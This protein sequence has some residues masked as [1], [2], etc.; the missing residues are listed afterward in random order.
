MKVF[1][2]D[3]VHLYKD[4]KGDYYSPSIYDDRFFDRFSDVFQEVYFCAKI[5]YIPN[6]ESTK[7]IKIQ[8]KDIIIVELPWFRG[9][10]GLLLN[11]LKVRSVIRR[12]MKKTDVCIFR[13][14]QV[15]SLIGYM[16]RQKK[17]FI[18]E[19]V[20]DPREYFNG[21]FRFVSLFYLKRMIKNAVGVSYI[22]KNILQ[23]KYPIRGN[24][25]ITESYLTIDID[26]NLLSKPRIYP[27]TIKEFK[28]IH[29]A[30]NIESDSKGHST[31][32]N[33]VNHVIKNGYKVSVRFIG[34]GSFV[35][36]YSE[37]AES[38]NIKDY[39]HFIGRI[40]DKNKIYHE[41]LS[42]DLF[43]F[44]T[45]H[46]GLG[47]VNLEAQVCGLPCLASPV[48]GVV[49]LYDMKYLINPYD[50]Q[51]YGNKIIELINNPKELDR[52][53]LENIENVKQYLKSKNYSKR[54]DFYIK[55]KSIVEFP[56]T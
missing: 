27:D 32:I 38:L 40:H 49:E 37:M 42:A 43:I 7:F 51:S 50:Y 31:V 48:G 18:I 52:M 13:S 24:N 11:Y 17:P 30:N 54:H 55:F 41:L 36:Y 46:E 29:I 21:I 25:K 12:F 8:R 1:V 33:A 35:K 9:L 14:V 19:L 26:D 20:N 45:H 5:N 22:T 15:E 4:I 10:K 16:N 2:I 28:L 6:I 23:S 34:E 56:T 53:S 3:N 44:P 39:V 47:R